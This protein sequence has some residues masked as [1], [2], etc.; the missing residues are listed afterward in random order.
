MDPRDVALISE[1]LDAYLCCVAE[2]LLKK[3]AYHLSSTELW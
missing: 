2:D 3:K 1:V